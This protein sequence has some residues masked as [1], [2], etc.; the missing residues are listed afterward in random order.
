[1]KSF[2]VTA[3]LIAVVTTACNGGTVSTS[4]VPSS[5]PVAS[6]SPTTSPPAASTAAPTAGTGTTFRSSIYP[7]TMQLPSGWQVASDPQA[8]E[9]ED[10]FDGPDDMT[11]TIGSAQPEPGQTVKDR[12]AANRRSDFAGCKT[13]PASDMPITL[14][15]EAGILW[16][17]QCGPILGLAANTIH[18]GV[19][20]RLLVKLPD[21][22]QTMAQA[23]AVM[24]GFRASFAF[25]N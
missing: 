10:V 9:G 19:G 3:I 12:V 2:R 18:D 20:Y 24:D 5:P 16:S 25:T 6:A 4:E 15:G 21:G 8:H 22:A 7:Y 17:V 14:G 13:D 23:T 11:L 1:M